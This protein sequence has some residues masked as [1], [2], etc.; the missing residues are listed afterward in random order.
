VAATALKT[1][2]TLGSDQVQY[3]FQL[4]QQ[5][6]IPQLQQT[7]T[8]AGGQ[9]IQ[10]IPTGGGGQTI[11]LAGQTPS[12]ALPQV[13]QVTA[14]GQLVSAGGQ[15][16]SVG[17]QQ[18]VQIQQAGTHQTAAQPPQQ[19]QQP[20]QIMQQVIGANE[21]QQ[22][23]MQGALGA[24][25]QLIRMPTQTQNGTT[26]ANQQAQQP[27][28]IQTGQPQGQTLYLPNG[29]QVFL[30]PNALQHLT[31]GGAVDDESVIGH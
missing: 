28:I 2:T 29:Q 13:L 19:T 18:V 7:I 8:T 5:N 4:A 26:Q 23:Q 15:T 25:L 16:V 10:I 6:S 12:F 27:I 1:A 11:Q 9:Q 24:Q 17:G 22:L 14:D 21:L 31:N 20:L 30:Q 3:L